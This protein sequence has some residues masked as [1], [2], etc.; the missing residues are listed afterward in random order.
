MLA[1]STPR[2][3]MGLRASGRRRAATERP[4]LGVPIR[5]ETRLDRPRDRLAEEA[6]DAAQEVRL[7]DRDEAHGVAG[8]AGPPGPAD[9]VDVVMGLPRQLEVHDMREV[10][11]VE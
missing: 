11:D 10:L 6:L 9:A 5:L 3:V 2:L 7:V 1:R 8:R 4:H